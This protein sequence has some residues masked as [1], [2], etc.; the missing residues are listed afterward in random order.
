MLRDFLP[1]TAPQVVTQKGTQYVSTTLISGGKS[2]FRMTS[3]WLIVVKIVPTTQAVI[4]AFRGVPSVVASCINSYTVKFAIKDPCSYFINSSSAV[5][6][7]KNAFIC[8]VLLS[9]ISQSPPQLLLQF[10]LELYHF[11]IPRPLLIRE[12][13][14]RP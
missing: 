8:S 7:S 6:N 14:L 1:N 2:P 10:I 4:S 13:S 9:K 11:R 5:L 12:V 3:P